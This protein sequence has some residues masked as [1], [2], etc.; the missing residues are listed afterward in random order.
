MPALRRVLTLIA[1]L[2][3]A[4][5]LAASTLAAGDHV[6]RLKLGGVIDQVNAAYIEEGLTAAAEGGAA[7]VIIEVDS[8]GGELTSM[9]RM[10]KAILASPIPVIT[11]VAPEGAQAASAATFVTLAGDVAA[12]APN[13][14][15]GAASVVGGSGE[16]LGQTLYDKITNSNAAKIT[17]LARDHGRN[18]TWAEEAVREAKSASASE[19]VG[20][21]PPVVDLVAGS[22]AELLAAIDLG[23]RPDGYAYSF[24]GAPLPRLAD[25]PIRDL[26]MNFGQQFLHILS[27]P[28]IAFILFTV[29][30]YGLI[31]EVFHPNFAS[32]I[33]GVIALVLAFI[34]SNSLPLN[35]GGLILLLI[36][37][38]LFVL[39]LN[40]TSYG[41]LTVGG[42]ISFALGAFALYTGV[43][44]E[45]VISEVQVS[46]WLLVLVLVITLVYFFGLIRALMGM[47]SRVTFA[48]PMSGLVGASG[49][50]QTLIGTSGIA[51]A[52]GEAWSARAES[53]EIP[54][55]APVRVVRVDGLELIVEPTDGA[56]DNPEKGDEPE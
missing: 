8:P 22:T 42:I 10:I 47:R 55:G 27:D 39:E 14:T 25:L 38:G 44:Q 15:I 19:A 18:E 16:D 3:G 36:G 35:V 7:A 45:Q 9:D 23:E 5:S 32:G 51:Y 12:M 21:S 26:G 1:L 17:E 29:G 2:L 40:V 43:D 48:H 11:Y 34:G 31:A 13:T 30:F 52:G 24:D 54:P 33:I 46:P 49:V 50:A 4:A 41:L 20:M 56:G 28:N 37:V 53:G 6:A